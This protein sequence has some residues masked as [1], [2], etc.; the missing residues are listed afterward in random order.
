MAT[1]IISFDI[2]GVFS[3]PPPKLSIIYGGVKIGVTY[4][5][6]GS[7]TMSFQIDSDMPI[8]HS[9]LRF[10]S[11]KAHGSDGDVVNISNI[12]IDDN[13]IDMTAFTHNKGSSSDSTTLSLT[14]GSYS[15]YD[16]SSTIVRSDDPI[17]EVLATISGDAGDNK[18]YGTDLDDII[19]GLAG[20]DKI[21]AKSGNDTVNGGD[22]NDV[23][24]GQ[25]GADIL[26]GDAGDDKIYGNDGADTINGGLGSDRLYGHEGVD[27]IHGNDGDD[28]IWGGQDGDFIYGDIGNDRLSGEAGNDYI[29]GGAGV[30]Q[31][32][33]GD[34]DDTI[35]G[36][37]DN[38]RII[39]ND[40]NDTL[41]GDAGDDNID[42]QYGNDTINGGVGNDTLDGEQGDDI[43]NGDDGDDY[44]VGGA[45]ADTINGGTGNDIIFGGGVSSYEQYNIRD[46]SSFGRTGAWFSEQ[47]QSFYA[48]VTANVNYAGAETGARAQF[49]GGVRGRLATITSQEELD[50]VNL[51]S[52]GTQNLWVSGTDSVSEGL[53][54]YTSGYEQGVEFWSGGTAG[55]NI[56][57]A[58]VPW[59]AGQPNDPDDTQDYNYLLESSDQL[60]DAPFVSGGGFLTITG[61]IVEWSAED[62]I[63][64]FS[65]NTLN[66]GSGS[67]TIYGASGID[68][69]NGGNNSDKLYGYDGNDVMSGGSGN[70]FIH[71][72]NGNDDL[73]GGN[74]S[75]TIFGGTITEVSLLALSDIKAYGNGQDGAST[76][77]L[78]DDGVGFGVTGNAW[79][80]TGINYN[81]TANTVLEFDFRS[82]AEGEIHGIGFDNDLGIDSSLSFK[83]Y[84]TQNWGRGNFDNYDGSGEWVHYK[85]DVGS[86]YTGQYANLFFVNDHDVGSPTAN[87]QF[88]NVI[89]H[90][91]DSEINTYTGGDGVDD[92]Y[93]SGGIDTFVFESGNA[94]TSPDRIHN[95]D[96][97]TDIL[98]VSDLITGFTG[99]ANM[100]DFV[101]FV[102]SGDH[103]LLQVDTDGLIGGLNFQTVATIY[104]GA[105][106]DALDLGLSGNIAAV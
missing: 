54:R 78:F 48:V 6:T 24:A 1:H 28:F 91:D 98:D 23:I 101:Q 9:L 53:W 38:D 56:N 93:G 96:A 36:G 94:F 71:G 73:I 95:F 12:R 80:Y 106:L 50:F 72:G 77:D 25:N 60:A 87:S 22:G 81:I 74:G 49:M 15:D 75:D 104:G 63:A 99:I 68:I 31:I 92:L 59:T 105:E 88:R 32:F 76:V 16:T 65:T 43:I 52:G 10:Y 55:T 45:G 46:V 67:D 3:G 21:I 85:I 100:L 83:L 51:L 103:S 41:N 62:I 79:K 8:N 69:I 27:V 47:T 17:P 34:G 18:I 102:D 20:N 70:D 82:T 44:I 61:Y 90:E 30:D 66:G 42:G 19:N 84:G 5:D 39:G 7:S 4:V 64:D 58:Y 97:T 35:F 40:G 13:P 37:D 89:I 33:G 14:R 2:S 57:I 29:E 11:I 26:N 86:F